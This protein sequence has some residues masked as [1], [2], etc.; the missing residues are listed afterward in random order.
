VGQVQGGFN[1]QVTGVV[2]DDSIS[3]SGGTVPAA[4]VVWGAINAN[5]SF[6]LNAD[7][8][9]NTHGSFTLGGVGIQTFVYFLAV[10]DTGIAA[11]A[12]LFRFATPG[13][14]LLA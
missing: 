2:I 12:D 4:A 11:L 8:L 13:P 9:L 3:G 6:T 5:D 10:N 7:T 1:N 14:E